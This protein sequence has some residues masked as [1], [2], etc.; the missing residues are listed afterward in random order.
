MPQKQWVQGLGCE[1]PMGGAAS[2][3]VLSGVCMY[4]GVGGMEGIGEGVWDL[5]HP[6]KR[7][8]ALGVGGRSSLTETQGPHHLLYWPWGALHKETA[9]SLLAPTSWALGRV[10]EGQVQLWQCWGGHTKESRGRDGGRAGWLSSSFTHVG[11]GVLPSSC[12]H[13]YLMLMR[14]VHGYI[15]LLSDDALQFGLSTSEETVF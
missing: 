10:G 7:Q 1:K 6:F 3:Q 2:E 5:S 13:F 4:G 9:P 14:V 12:N 11:V 8:T 15:Y